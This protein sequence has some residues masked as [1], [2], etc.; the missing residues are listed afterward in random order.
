MPVAMA[1]PA[2]MSLGA[3]AD[4]VVDVRLLVLELLE[5]KISDIALAERD[6]SISFFR[7]ALYLGRIERCIAVLIQYCCNAPVL[8]P[9]QQ[10]KVV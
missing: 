1:A 7:S 3:I 4:K 9:N 10:S 8:R 2:S 6:V 5:A